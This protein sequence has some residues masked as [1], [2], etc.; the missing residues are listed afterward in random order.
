MATGYRIHQRYAKALREI[1]ETIRKKLDP[2]IEK[3]TRDP[4]AIRHDKG[5]KKIAGLPGQVFEYRLGNNFRITFMLQPN[6]EPYLLLVGDHDSILT[7]TKRMLKSNSVQVSCSPPV[8]LYEPKP[9][10]DIQHRYANESTG[11]FSNFP[12]DLFKFWGI[13]ADM[14]PMLRSLK[15]QNE[16]L[17]IQNLSPA[18]QY[19]LLAYVIEDKIIRPEDQQETTLGNVVIKAV[20][21]NR[22]SASS[23]V[24]K[25]NLGFTRGQLSQLGI[26][27]PTLSLVLKAK[28]WSD[29]DDV[30]LP[31]KITQRLQEL[32]SADRL[33]GLSPEYTVDQ[34]ADDNKVLV[35]YYNGDLKRLLLFLA[36]EQKPLVDLPMD[37][38]QF[39]KGVAGSG[40]TTVAIYRANR[41]LKENPKA[42]VL[43]MTYSKTLAHS[44]KEILDDIL[45]PQD[46]SRIETIHFHKW[47]FDLI[48]KQ[49]KRS[50]RIIKEETRLEMIQ[51]SIELV[52]KETKSK[53]LDRPASWFDDE[54]SE[55]IKGRGFKDYQ[56]YANAERV[57]RATSLAEGGR[58]VVWDVF[59]AYQKLLG[60][61]LDWD[62]LP[63]RCFDI[64]QNKDTGLVYDHVIID[65]AQDL[66]PYSLKL[67]LSICKTGSPSSF[68]VADAAQSI[69]RRGFRWKDIG[70]SLHG[71]RIH[72]LNHTYRN[73]AEILQ[74]ANA[75]L[76]GHQ[77]LRDDGETI[78]ACT[79]TIRHG[80]KPTIASLKGFNEEA[81]YIAEQICRIHSEKGVPW[82]SIASLSASNWH[83]NQL[84]R[85]L[86]RKQIPTRIQSDN[87]FTI[88]S[89]HVKLLTLHSAKGL[90]FP[91]VFIFDV[92]KGVLP[93]K[94][95]NEDEDEIA[96]V[97]NQA[98]KLLYVGMTRA[99]Q[100]LYITTIQKKVS[101]LLAD[102]PEE[103]VERV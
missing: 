91:I 69:Y 98:R 49:N 38:I 29:L 15:N 58:K 85:I 74:A 76:D 23:E 3:L 40:K 94:P 37:G 42:K 82:G 1:P 22:A 44:A 60:S 2:I 102:I 10:R 4:E 11:P 93:R 92:E 46:A 87:D 86:H 39:V 68:V 61:R 8:E 48:S 70:V 101:P 54:I 16:A 25:E 41:I 34:F 64:I 21:T 75:L 100:E 95:Q 66:S 103:L 36:P 62:D 35:D 24:R 27:E 5:C 47:M 51:K 43:F 97:N 7:D 19:C 30:A 84:Q 73:T 81:T 59:L 55:A 45:L 26:A 80:P 53:L 20:D 52:G 96:E 17:K 50:P 12:D 72:A 32:V 13:P 99:M 56:E 67:A 79:N 88:G 65:E 90:E 31:V 77:D 89:D 71:S 63:A 6:R 57:G 33:T 18:A 28:T 9:E 14:W 78:V 83:S